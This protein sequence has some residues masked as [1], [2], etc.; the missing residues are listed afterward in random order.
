MDEEQVRMD[1]VREMVEEL[2]RK[3]GDMQRGRP[4]VGGPLSTAEWREV[5]RRLERW[6]EKLAEVGEG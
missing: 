1:V 4:P 5:L 3:M 2:W 6:V